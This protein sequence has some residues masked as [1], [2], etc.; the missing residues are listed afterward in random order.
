MWYEIE[1]LNNETELARSFEFRDFK[2][3]FSFCTKVALIA[4]KL[5]HHPSITIDYNK[6]S[7]STTT[8]DSGNRITEKDRQLTAEI[9]KLQL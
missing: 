6:V 1:N 9:D 5:N 7:I 2:E 3:A 8:H 4:E